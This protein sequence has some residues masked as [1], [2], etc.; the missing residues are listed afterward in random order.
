M[1]KRHRVLFLDDSP[2]SQHACASFRRN[3]IETA[4]VKVDPQNPEFPPQKLPLLISGEGQLEGPEAVG[5]YVETAKRR[6]G[7]S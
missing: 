1:R 2:E 5:R 4:E 7:K 3:K 6:A